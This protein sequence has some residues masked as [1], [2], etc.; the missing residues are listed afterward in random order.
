M[1][2]AFVPPLDNGVV[3]RYG[4]EIHNYA[5]HGR[6]RRR[7]PLQRFPHQCS[8]RLASLG[9]LPQH[10]RRRLHGNLFCITACHRQLQGPDEGSVW[11]CCCAQFLVSSPLRGSAEGCWQTVFPDVLEDPD[12][13]RLG[14]VRRP[15]LGHQLSSR[16]TRAF[17]HHAGIRTHA[18]LVNKHLSLTIAVMSNHVIFTLVPTCM[19]SEEN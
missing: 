11:R 13:G 1:H 19:H 4:V 6:H 18:G 17:P 2:V 14:Y 12:Q 8:E 5:P 15:V 10:R 16:R 7:C 3:R 9:T